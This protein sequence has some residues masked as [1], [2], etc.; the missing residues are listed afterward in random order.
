MSAY[1]PYSGAYCAACHHAK[2]GEL[3][4]ILGARTMSNRRAAEL[5]GISE[6]SIRRHVKNH[7]KPAGKAPNADAEAARRARLAQMQADAGDL[8]DA[9]F[10]ADALLQAATDLMREARHAKDRRGALAAGAL[11]EKAL[12]CKARMGD[13]AGST[14]RYVGPTVIL[15]STNG[16]DEE[17]T[18]VDAFIARLP[19]MGKGQARVILP[20]NN[21]DD[22]RFGPDFDPHD[23]ETWPPGYAG[24]SDFKDKNPR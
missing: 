17:V 18:D 21:R 16:T 7:L 22:P 11:I 12:A 14:G 23:S 24:A 8:G 15:V 2:A 4:A 9:P 13:D 3:N 20:S 19:S 5:F 10:D 1:Q 6:S